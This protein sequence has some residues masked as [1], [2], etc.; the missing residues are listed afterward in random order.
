M[1][2]SANTRGPDAVKS[3]LLAAA[4]ACLATSPTDRQT[5]RATLE[6]R[7]LTHAGCGADELTNSFGSITELMDAW[8]CE[9]LAETQDQV[10]AIEEQS[11]STFGERIEALTFIL[12]DSLEPFPGV[13]HVLFRRYAAPL[14]SHFRDQLGKSVE[15]ATTARD[16]P[17]VNLL[18]VDSAASRWVLAE[19]IIRLV[20]ESLADDTADRSRSAALV[21]RSLAVVTA[22]ATDPVAQRVT[23]LVRYA[24]EADYLPFRR[25]MSSG[26]ADETYE[27][28]EAYQADETDDTGETDAEGDDSSDV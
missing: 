1:D 22:V 3:K 8:F 14:R 25:F 26:S 16:V 10:N 27:T 2:N 4:S 20:E 19:T 11:G 13:D 28:D 18:V 12:L 23:D 21:D 7:V 17:A 24:W 6:T 5:H 9:R 15:A